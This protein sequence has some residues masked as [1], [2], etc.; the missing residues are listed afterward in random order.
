VN[1]KLWKMDICCPHDPN[2]SKRA[3]HY[4][5]L[6][7]DEL[8]LAKALKRAHIYAQQLSIYRQR[9]TRVKFDDATSTREG[10]D[11]QQQ[12]KQSSSGGKVETSVVLS[13]A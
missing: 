3:K 4:T 5:L 7:R 1:A 2:I 6:A 11:E 9:T 12:T 8:T 10:L 13:S